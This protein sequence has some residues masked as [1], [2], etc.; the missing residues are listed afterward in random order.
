MRS[1]LVASLLM[2][3]AGEALSLSLDNGT[4]HHRSHNGH[5]GRTGH[6]DLTERIE[7]RE[8][9]VARDVSYRCQGEIYHTRLPYNP[10]RSIKVKVD[11]TPL[12]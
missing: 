10:G 4:A 5:Y 7:W 11:V 8:D 6:D 3:A 12:G 1:H 2:L 9:A